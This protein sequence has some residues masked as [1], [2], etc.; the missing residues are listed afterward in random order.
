MQKKGEQIDV[1]AVNTANKNRRNG[2]IQEENLY[3]IF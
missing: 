1:T 3:G 2:A